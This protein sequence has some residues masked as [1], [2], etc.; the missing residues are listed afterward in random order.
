MDVRPF[1]V[2]HLKAMRLQPSQAGRSHL[3]QG[4]V[5]EFLAG[6]E[7]YTAFADGQPVAACGLA[8][9]W[10]G[11]AMA[12]AF[13]AENAGPHLVGITRAVRKF[14]DLKAPARTELY[15]DADFEPGRRWAEMLGFSCETPQPMR[16]FE[17][18]GRAQYM[19]SRVR[20]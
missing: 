2:D 12:W 8:E 18:D 6:L 5:L 17:P 9:I 20:A 16:N 10:P 15:V 4:E 11:R 3:L 19:Y 14:L 7:A 13:L 1:H